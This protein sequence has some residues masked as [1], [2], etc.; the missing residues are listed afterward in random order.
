MAECG[1]EP[2]YRARL[3]TASGVVDLGARM[4]TPDLVL[5]EREVA[6]FLVSSAVGQ[7]A[8]AC[9]EPDCCVCN[10]FSAIWW[11]LCNALTPHARIAVQRAIFENGY[12]LPAGPWTEE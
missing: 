3:A 5:T 8:T 12:T 1:M 9:T 11:D 4:R 6:R 7:C 2:V 10:E